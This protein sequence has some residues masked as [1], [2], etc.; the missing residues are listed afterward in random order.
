[1]SSLFGIV[2]PGR[3]VV[4]DFQPISETKAVTLLQN[5]SLITEV[6]FFLLQPCPQGFGAMLYYSTDQVFF[7]YNVLLPRYSN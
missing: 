4:T 1:M 3:P 6:T 2:V 7:A 5:P